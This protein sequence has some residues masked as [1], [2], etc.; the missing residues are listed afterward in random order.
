MRPDLGSQ[1]A[2]VPSIEPSPSPILP[3]SASRSR[4]STNQPTEPRPRES[5]THRISAMSQS[6]SPPLS[7]RPCVLSQQSPRHQRF[8]RGEPSSP[9]FQSSP[10]SHPLVLRQPPS[11]RE[12]TPLERPPIQATHPPAPQTAEAGRRHGRSTSWRTPNAWVDL[13]NPNLQPSSLESKC[14]PVPGKSAPRENQSAHR[15]AGPK[16]SGQHQLPWLTSCPP[17]PRVPK[18]EPSRSHPSLL[19]AGHQGPWGTPSSDAT[20]YEAPLLVRPH[21]HSSTPDSKARPKNH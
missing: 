21:F 3:E 19:A 16:P 6:T 20:E 12:S 4:S 1:P 17:A 10:P 11:P 7:Q 8:P 2:E 13:R 5:P 9:A 14:P 18:A 15:P